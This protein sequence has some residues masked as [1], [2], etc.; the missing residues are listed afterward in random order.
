MNESQAVLICTVVLEHSLTG[1]QKLNKPPESW[2]LLNKVGEEKAFY[3][4]LICAGS[5]KKTSA[6]KDYIFTKILSRYAQQCKF[7]FLTPCSQSFISPCICP[8]HFTK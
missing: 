1:S 7:R 6:V 8:R 2:S 5:P 4:S 3:N